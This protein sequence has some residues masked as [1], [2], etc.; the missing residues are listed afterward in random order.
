VNVSA[1]IST[2]NLLTAAKVLIVG[3]VALCATALSLL[4]HSY[5][6]SPRS[7]DPYDNL[8]Q[9]GVGVHVAIAL[10]P[11]VAVA[12]LGLLSLMCAASVDRSSRS[13]S[14]FIWAAAALASPLTLAIIFFLM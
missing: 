2:K 10:I 5:I 6:V 11:G 7:S 9:I 8:D 1:Q 3:N 12:F 13:R 4:A 14:T